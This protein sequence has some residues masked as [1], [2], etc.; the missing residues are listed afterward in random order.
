MNL[1]YL[2][3]IIIIFQHSYTYGPIWMRFLFK[4]FRIL[5]I[6]ENRL[7]TWE[8]LLIVIIREFCFKIFIILFSTKKNL[9]F[10]WLEFRMHS[11]HVQRKQ[12]DDLVAWQN[13]FQMFQPANW[14]SI[15]CRWLELSI[16]VEFETALIILLVKFIIDFRRVKVTILPS[17]RIAFQI[18]RNIFLTI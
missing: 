15:L 11:K 7:H 1:C 8:I 4:G 6:Y 17:L 18:A 9:K 2:F 16:E 13:I 10:L 3:G 5:V 12:L 14:V